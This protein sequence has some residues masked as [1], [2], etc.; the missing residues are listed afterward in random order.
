MRGMLS[1]FIHHFW[2]PLL[3][4]A[5]VT[6]LAPWGLRFARR[7][8]RRTGTDPYCSQCEYNLTGLP[9]STTRCPECGHEIRQPG[10]TVI[11]QSQPYRLRMVLLL[12]MSVAVLALTVRLWRHDIATCDFYRLRTEA[13]LVEQL[14]T[15]GGRVDS[16]AWREMDRRL[17]EGSLAARN[18]QK[19]IASELSAG[20]LFIQYR[21]NFMEACLYRDALDD[22]LA[23]KVLL[24]RLAAGRTIM[25]TP[26][27]FTRRFWRNAAQGILGNPKGNWNSQQI[28]YV[29]R[30]ANLDLV[31]R[32]RWQ[33]F[34]RA[35]LLSRLS[36]VSR[37]AVAPGE[38]WPVWIDN[39]TWDLSPMT[40]TVQRVTVA[41][42]P[43]TCSAR[44]ENSPTGA[45]INW[46]TV[47]ASALASDSP[48]PGDYTATFD[49]HIEHPQ[50]VFN[51]AYECR[52]KIL[53]PGET[54][55]TAV[56]DE[57][58]R[59]QIIGQTKLWLQPTASGHL[60]YCSTTGLSVALAG[61]FCAQTPAGP[62]PFGGAIC[63][64]GTNTWSS[65]PIKA[66]PPFR[67]TYE[68]DRDA[69]LRDPG[70]DSYYALPIDFGI[71][72]IRP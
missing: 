54:G 31:S 34:H 53:S 18:I 30:C 12:A 29:L 33:E 48:T 47:D 10:G 3:L 52:V 1:F 57:A 16:Y 28:D 22:G 49:L 46:G 55:V 35:R 72:A 40:I 67:V 66:A 69:A 17:R 58:T 50:L 60:F 41:G 38:F 8:R 42:R 65:G 26:R 32:D 45:S 43:C 36:V 11:G 21:D 27:P 15:P 19:L 37:K 23:E 9:V 64:H 39:G 2:I 71:I 44:V 4:T 61:T 6:L 70:V 24:G 13:S 5:A 59:S 62:V 63:L 25:P 20:D 14:I 51:H 56:R 68:P 7:C